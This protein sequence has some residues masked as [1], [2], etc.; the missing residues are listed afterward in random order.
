MARETNGSRES[1]A[2]VS[3]TVGQVEALFRL[4]LNAWWLLLLAHGAGAGMR[5]PSWKAWRTNWPRPT[6]AISEAAMRGHDGTRL[7]TVERSR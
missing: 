2:Q 4:P 5:Q 7:D 6:G 3:E 1:R